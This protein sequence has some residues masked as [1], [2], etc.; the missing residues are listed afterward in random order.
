MAEF[1]PTDMDPTP[2]AFTTD[3][4]AARQ[5][6]TEIVAR[7]ATTDGTHAT[8]IQG[9]QLLRTSVPSEPI[10]VMYRPAL[11]LLLGGRKRVFLSDQVTEYSPNCH[12]VVSQDLPVLGE[13]IEASAEQPY[14][15]LHFLIEPAEVAALM[16]DVGAPREPSAA[17]QHAARGLYTEPTSVELMDAMLRLVHLLDTP[18]DAVV[19]APMVRREILY[20]LL[21]APNGWRMARTVRVDSHEQRVSRVIGLMRDRFRESLTITQL[22]D[23]AH[24][25]PSALHLH[26][27]SVTGLTPLQYLKQLKLQEA[28]KLMLS[29]AIDAASAGYLVGYESPSHF[30]RDYARL[31]GAPPARDRAQWLSVR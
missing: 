9:L 12:L 6:M 8:P 17:S 26:F 30:S 5:R 16:L 4:R 25:S 21:S 10:S 20:R 31:F 23:V 1:V 2:L 15:C 14:L 3:H 29:E 7:H 27:K 28:R 22:A 13:V 19:L 18:A 11:C 24:L